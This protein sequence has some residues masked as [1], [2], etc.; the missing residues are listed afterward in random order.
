MINMKSLTFIFNLLF[1]GLIQGC[2]PKESAEEKTQPEKLNVLFIVS[3]DLRIELG[4]YGY[5]Y[6]ITPNIDKLAAEGRIFKEAHVQ[7][8]ICNPSRMSFLTGLRPDDIEVH[9]NKTSLSFPKA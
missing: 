8:A 7:Q 2:L 4:A 9:G 1:L 5:D 3:D 6:M